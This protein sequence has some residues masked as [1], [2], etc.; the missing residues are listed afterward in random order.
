MAAS[1]AST[2]VAGLPGRAQAYLAAVALATVGA[3]VPAL[4]GMTVDRNDLVTFAL[5]ALGAAIAQTGVIEISKNHGF[6]VA[7][8]FVTAAALLLPLGLVA[9]IAL[10]QH[11]PDI[12]RRK[13]PWYIQTFNTSNFTLNVLAAAVVARVIADVDATDAGRFA[14]AGLAACLVLVA[15]NHVLLATMLRFARGH[16]FR[17]SGLFSRESLS[18][19]FVLAALGVTLA[20]LATSN[21]LLVVGTIAPLLLVHRL[22]QQMAR[23]NGAPARAR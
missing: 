9:L 12:V 1:N 5:L 14:V 19:D 4:A 6:P 2:R 18:I 10:A 21:P 13:Y 3:A 11:A 15:T 23:A 7:I 20:A 16:S 8:A 17:E 22:L